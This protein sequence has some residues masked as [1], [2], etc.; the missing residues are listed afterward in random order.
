M[1]LGPFGII[2]AVGQGTPAQNRVGPTFFK[3]LTVPGSLQLK[4]PN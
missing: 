2:N 4:L 1:V 3:V